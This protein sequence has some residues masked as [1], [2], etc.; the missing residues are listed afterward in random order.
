MTSAWTA[1]PVRRT[2]VDHVAAER[3]ALEQWLDHHR[4][5]LLGMCTGVT[6]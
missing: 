3:L 6:G 4:D 1:P 5:I 2:D